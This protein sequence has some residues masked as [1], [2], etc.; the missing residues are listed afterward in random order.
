M[1]LRRATTAADVAHAVL[2]LCSEESRN[3]TGQGLTVDG[4]W[5]V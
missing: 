5:N 1:A 3:M 2:F 4:G